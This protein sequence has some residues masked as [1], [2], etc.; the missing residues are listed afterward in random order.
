M[1]QT[2]TTKRDTTPRFPQWIKRSL[3]WSETAKKVE[4]IIKDLGIHTVCQSASC[5]NRHE[6]FSKNKATFMILGNIC[7]RAC[8]F[9]SVKKGE[10]LKIDRLEPK[11]L[12]SALKAMNLKH[13]VITSVTRDD[14]KD[15]G[16]NQF[17]TVIERIKRDNPNITIEALTPDF[18]GNPDSLKTILSSPVDIFAHNLETVPRLYNTVRP[19][20]DYK[21]SLFIIKTANK[22]GIKTKSGIMLGLGETK[23]EVHSVIK[24]LK[25]AG[26]LYLTL[27]QYLRPSK[28][29]LEVHAF[30]RP[31]IFECYRKFALSLGFKD[32][33]AGPFARTSYMTHTLSVIPVSE[34]S[35]EY[36]NLGN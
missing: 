35:E 22:S 7:T 13:A 20:A 30:I 32:V 5:P 24:D 34:R 17:K 28:K 8:R 27:G 33:L 11:K 15:G 14:L 18:M 31:E 2:H 12:S 16:A 3:T 1:L 36:R 6:C 26:C 21:R 25:K 19:K 4:N 10:P 23:E 9:C 29:E